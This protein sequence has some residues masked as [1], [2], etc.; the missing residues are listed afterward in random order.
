M[1]PIRIASVALAVLPLVLPAALAAQDGRLISTAALITVVEN[2]KG[3]VLRYIDAAPDSMLGFRPTPGV[4]TF[5]QQI[6]H[7]AGSDALIAHLAI[8]GTTRNMPS[9][10]DSAV[11]LHDKAALKKYAAAAMDHTIA[12]LRGVSDAAMNENIVQFGNKVTRGRALMELL[13]HFPWT[14]GQTVPYLRLN[15]VTPP[16]YSPF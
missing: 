13:D 5:A 7:A 1:R 8:T 6:E 14:L 2:H 12:M 10:G 9:M 16:E 15:G 4:R 11:Y 3:A